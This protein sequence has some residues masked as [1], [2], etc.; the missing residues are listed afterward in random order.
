MKTCFA[1]GAEL[2]VWIILVWIILVWIILV[3]IILVWI[4]LDCGLSLG[5]AFEVGVRVTLLRLESGLPFLGIRLRLES[6]YPFR[7]WS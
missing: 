7:F 2:R 1:G 5:Y 4:I 3:W 6:G